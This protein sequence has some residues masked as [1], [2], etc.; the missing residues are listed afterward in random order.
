MYSSYTV[1]DMNSLW[2]F[3]GTLIA[4]SSSKAP[5]KPRWIEF[6]LYKTSSGTYILSRV[7]QSILFHSK[8]CKTVTR[9]K[10]TPIAPNMLSPEAAMCLDCMPIAEAE[11]E[12]YPE[13]PRYF[14]QKTTTAK[15]VIAAVTQHDENNSE[16]LTNVA[17]RLLLQAADNDENIGQVLFDRYVD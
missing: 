2:H 12:L 4:S 5:N 8:S 1:R 6:D 14:A 3:E 13:T 11:S 16:Y 17:K 10:L 7:G 9:N 15:G